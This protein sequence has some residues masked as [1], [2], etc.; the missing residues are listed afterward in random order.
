MKSRQSIYKKKLKSGYSCYDCDF[1]LKSCNKIQ[2]Y[3]EIGNPVIVW[4]CNFCLTRFVVEKD[5][6]TLLEKRIYYNLNNKRYC[7]KYTYDDILNLDSS[8]KFE[9]LQ[10][11]SAVNLSLYKT[12][13]KL[14]FYPL[15]NPSSFDKLQ[16]M[17]SFS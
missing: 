8:S 10:I 15:L 17:I 1:C 13:I 11:L 7:A 12:I 3:K 4:S 14:D 5:S 16:T 2:E 9:L 6:N